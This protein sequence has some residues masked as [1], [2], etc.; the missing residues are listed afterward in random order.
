MVIKEWFTISFIAASML[1]SNGV[2]AE[3][4]LIERLV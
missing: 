4:N 1:L 2:L 3:K